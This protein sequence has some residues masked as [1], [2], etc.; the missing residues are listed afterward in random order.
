M[1][2]Q[3]WLWQK[4]NLRGRLWFYSHCKGWSRS[5]FLY[6]HFNFRITLKQLRIQLF[7]LVRIRNQLF[8]M[9]IRILLLIVWVHSH[10]RL[11]FELLKLLNFDYNEWEHNESILPLVMVK[12]AYLVD[13]HAILSL[14]LFLQCGE[15]T[16]SCRFCP[17]QSR[18]KRKKFRFD[19]HL[20]EPFV[21]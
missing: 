18:N 6:G 12:L 19:L 14:D 17:S 21:L 9:R 20:S 11:N 1:N 8:T 4:E 15:S 10:P 2:P 16:E 7:T 3:H 5:W 13:V